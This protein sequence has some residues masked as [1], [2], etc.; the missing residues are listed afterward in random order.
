MNT[1]TL[2]L[3]LNFQNVQLF[4]DF[5]MTWIKNVNKFQIAKD[6]SDGAAQHLLDFFCQIQPSVAYKS[7]AHKKTCRCYKQCFYLTVMHGFQL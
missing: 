6:Q 5:W 2:V 1:D 7:V 4:L 3:L